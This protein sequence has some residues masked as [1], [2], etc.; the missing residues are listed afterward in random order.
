M[1]IKKL[2]TGELSHKAISG[3]LTIAEY[4]GKTF[5]MGIISYLSLMGAISIAVGVFNLLPVPMLD[6]GHLI[7]I[8]AEAITGRKLPAKA[9]M[10]I[11][12]VGVALMVALFLYVTT[13]DIFRLL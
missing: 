12:M 1:S 10:Y 5:Q 6:G 2:I 9:L 8:L 13:Q 4:S 7:I 11:Q 3:P